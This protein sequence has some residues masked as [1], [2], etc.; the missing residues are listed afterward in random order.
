MG[1]AEGV[2]GLPG[3]GIGYPANGLGGMPKGL[4]LGGGPDGGGGAGRPTDGTPL[5]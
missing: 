1:T 3:I 5:Q 4:P 2:P